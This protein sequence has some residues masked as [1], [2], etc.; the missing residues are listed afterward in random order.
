M[1]FSNN[2]ATRKVIPTS[3]NRERMPLI[4]TFFIVDP[5]KDSYAGKC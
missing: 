1:I 5:I 4:R 3:T 2:P